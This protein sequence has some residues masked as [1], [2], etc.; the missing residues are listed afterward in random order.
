LKIQLKPV[1]IKLCL[2]MCSRMVQIL[3]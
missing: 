1:I 3:A 2:Q